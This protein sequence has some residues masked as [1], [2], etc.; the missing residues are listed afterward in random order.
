M[1]QVQVLQCTACS[2]PS[3]QLASL[4]Q[5]HLNMACRP[6]AEEHSCC[7]QP[8]PGDLDPNSTTHHRS[9]IIKEDGGHH[10]DFVPHRDVRPCKKHST[11]SLSN[12]HI[13]HVCCSLHCQYELEILRMHGIMC[14]YLRGEHCSKTAMPK[15]CCLCIS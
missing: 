12:E 15:D 1:L 5:R 2:T 13:L 3:V 9:F 8:S 7:P 4:S 14:T 11:D 10:P 6:S